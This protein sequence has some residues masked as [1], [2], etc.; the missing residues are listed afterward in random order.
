MYISIL[1]QAKDSQASQAYPYFSPTSA[2][3]G[4]LSLK[5]RLALFSRWA[6]VSEISLSELGTLSVRKDKLLVERA[7]DALSA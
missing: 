6:R 3:K 1:S 5:A 4:F 7:D 2:F